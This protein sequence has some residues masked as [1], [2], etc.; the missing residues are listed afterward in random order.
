MPNGCFGSKVSNVR[1]SRHPIHF[2]ITLKVSREFVESSLD[3]EPFWK[4]LQEPVKRSKDLGSTVFLDQLLKND[5][6]ANVLLETKTSPMQ[7]PGGSIFPSVRTTP[8]LIDGVV[9]CGKNSA[10]P[11]RKIR[12]KR[13]LAHPSTECGDR[14]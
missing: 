1:Q 8:K 14:G 6:G 3:F 12:Y 11:W 5:S 13:R 2:R 7:S 4:F 10:T 9:S